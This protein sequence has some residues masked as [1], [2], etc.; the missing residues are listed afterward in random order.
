MKLLLD[1]L[2]DKYNRQ[3][4]IAEDPILIPHRYKHRKDI[5]ISGFLT[6]LLAWGSRPA[7]IRAA[8]QLMTL[9]EDSPYQFITQHT[10]DDLN[11]FNTFV[12]RTMQPEDI[13]FLITALKDIYLHH[14]GLESLFL[15]NVRSEN[16]HLFESIGYVRSVIM[17]TKHPS[18][19]EKHIADP[20]TGSAAKRINLFLRWMVRNDDRK[21]DLGLWK[22]IRPNQL[23]C[24]LDIHSG[25]AARALGLIARKT[26]DRKAAEELTEQLKTLDPADPVKYDFALFGLGR[27]LQNKSSG[28]TDIPILRQS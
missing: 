3:E 16:T 1:V 15:K 28:I 23:I 11:R 18:R 2:V 17:K 8:I 10:P 21:V 24:P 27:E 13:K 7:I 26:N 19:S 25:N 5:E 22:G 12:Y 9:L 4:F 6:A 20:S 14:Q